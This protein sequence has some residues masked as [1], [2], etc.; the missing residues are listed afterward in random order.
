ML[1]QRVLV[2]IHTIELKLLVE[3]E[4]TDGATQSNNGYLGLERPDE[5]GLVHLNTILRR[6][7]QYPL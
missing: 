3:L 1:I 7:R 4:V 6:C 5:G 2:I